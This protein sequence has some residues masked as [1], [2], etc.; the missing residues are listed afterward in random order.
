MNRPDHNAFDY[1]IA[2][3]LRFSWL[4]LPL[5]GFECVMSEHPLVPFEEGFVDPALVG[6]WLQTGEDADA[7]EVVISMQD[8]GLMAIDFI[9]KDEAEQPFYSYRGYA[10]R[11]GEET[12]AN[13]ELTD[14]G[15]L[16]CEPDY[17]DT[18]RADFFRDFAPIIAGSDAASC[19]FIIVRYEH[20]EDDRLIINWQELFVTP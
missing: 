15:C 14:M 5:M 1:L 8:D 2:R 6:R 7:A 4:L 18:I 10:S 13:L 12:Y 9:G 19:T 11:L 17:R 20:T 16:A 3:P